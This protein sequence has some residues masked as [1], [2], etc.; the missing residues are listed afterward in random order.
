[1]FIPKS[2]MPALLLMLNFY[3]D[4][5]RD[6][7]TTLVKEEDLEMFRQ[8]HDRAALCQHGDAP[9]LEV[10]VCYSNNPSANIKLPKGLATCGICGA[11]LTNGS[12]YN[13]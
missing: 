9:F 7:P 1:M 6:G 5:Y 11:E 8:I 13:C 10:E 3:L 4:V 2:K 12:C